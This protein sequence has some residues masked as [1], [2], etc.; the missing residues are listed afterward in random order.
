MKVR[1]CP[2]NDWSFKVAYWY[3]N[4]LRLWTIQVLDR[5]NDQ[6][7]NAHYEA[8][9]FHALQLVNELATNSKV[10]A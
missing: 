2:A 10:T 8:N 6:I 1:I 5:N 4:S 7:G 9:R 3:D